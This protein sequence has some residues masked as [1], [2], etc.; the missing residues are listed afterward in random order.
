MD[1][2][3]A[4]PLP[5]ASLLW[6][7]QPSAWALTVVCRATFAL[8]P[9]ESVLAADQEHPNELDD[10]WDDDPNR[11][12]RAAGDLVP[13]KTRADVT[14]VGHA[15]APGRVPVRSLVAH[16]IVGELSKSVE[17]V[18]DRFFDQDG[19]LHDGAPF[20]R[21]P[22][23]YERAAGG[24]GTVNPVGVS[25]VS[26]RYG[27]IALPNLQP[28]GIV[29]SSLDDYIA[30]VGFG[31][32]APS[33][34]SRRERLGRAAT[35]GTPPDLRRPLPDDLDPQYFNHAPRDQQVQLLREKE[36]LVL[37]N[38]HPEH[39]RFVTDLPG[40]RPRA[41]VERQGR[42][43][44]V[45]LRCDT[46]WIDTD[47]SLCTLSWRAQIPLQHPEEEGRV[48][49]SLDT[50]GQSG[51]ELSQLGR[52]QLRAPDSTVDTWVPSDRAA[53]PAADK[54]LPF[55][56]T[57]P[58]PPSP[59][60]LE[61]RPNVSAGL[62]FVSPTTAMRP[63][64]VAPPMA[65][66]VAPPMAP[67]VA[68]PMA[69]PPVAP[70]MAPPVAPPM[71]QIVAPPMAPPLLPSQPPE[72]SPS[73]R[74]S[75]WSISDTGAGK[76]AALT[77][78]Q[79]AAQPPPLPSKPTIPPVARPS[80][81]PPLPA[82]AAAPSAG[83]S[84]SVPAR[85]A[86]ASQTSEARP[87]ASPAERTPRAATGD[88][89]ADPA[90]APAKPEGKR[91]FQL[92]F[93]E[94]EGVPR[95]R[96]KP[97]FQP[98]LAALEDRPI[99]PELDDPALARDPA[100]VEDRRDVFEVLARGEPADEAGLDDALE[101]A[102]RSDGKFVPPFLLIAGE[103][104]FLF[105]DV[106]ALRATISLATP[107]SAGD[108]ALK[109]AL[110]D[111]RDLLTTP[112]LLGPSGLADHFTTRIQEAFRKARRQV[113]PTYLEDQV[114]RALLEKRLYQR[115]EVFGASHLR[116][117]LVM[118]NTLA[119]AAATI[120][121]PKAPPEPPRPWPIYLPQ[122]VL[123]KL[124]MFSRFT[125]RLLVTAHFQEDQFEPHP[126]AL[127]ALAL[128]RVVSVQSRSDKAAKAPAPGG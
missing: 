52:L 47:R 113:A 118:G 108:E 70:A 88:A 87:E 123:P 86:L 82:K 34:P 36:R 116:A 41:F 97:A 78:G 106:A 18:A 74:T 110:A 32:L 120:S 77:V 101:R 75:L 33:W 112:E 126:N 50:P 119:P 11:S 96:R 19:A 115:R 83:G 100:P 72:G 24:V 98:I 90:R 16:I 5:V 62:P 8:C 67:P 9:G 93:F 60:R 12:L 105:D 23:V 63:P 58:A 55:A 89:A 94:P 14:L 95:V 111:A 79:L 71:T 125:A 57:T 53:A 40:L 15:F 30:P 61:E 49:V 66:P 64:P 10:H 76:A 117:M 127:R 80:T 29:V 92:V 107:L 17:V 2:V 13:M 109:L 102:V 65:P 3:S 26:N 59:Q 38:L 21:M 68:P 31:P 103:L 124:P 1:V 46:L 43:Q 6:Q 25:G 81:P 51:K 122:G 42:S 44:P 104:R 45:P 22:L 35:S 27:R 28:P 56:Q 73:P 91:A 84:T 4:S 69:P 39:P 20:T 37:E 121:N 48:V 54:V 7:P 114:E 128:A 85:E 99:D